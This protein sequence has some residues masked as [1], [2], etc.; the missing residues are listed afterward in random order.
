MSGPLALAFKGWQREKEK[1]ERDPAV[2]DKI[3]LQIT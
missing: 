1:K 2:E 3:S